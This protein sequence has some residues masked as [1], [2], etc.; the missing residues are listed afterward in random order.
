MLA[1]VSGKVESIIPFVSKYVIMNICFKV[2]M[3]LSILKMSIRS[4]LCVQHYNEYS[5]MCLCLCSYVNFAK[6]V[7]SF[8][9]LRCTFSKLSMSF[10]MFG[11]HA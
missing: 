2:Y 11:L 9:A 3:F 4:P 1:A 10:A 7:N 8:A 5:L 6:P